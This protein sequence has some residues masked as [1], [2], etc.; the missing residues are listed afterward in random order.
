VRVHSRTGAM[1][2]LLK[3]RCGV[4]QATVSFLALAKNLELI[5]EIT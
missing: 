1:V 3:K 4:A 5:W 2:L